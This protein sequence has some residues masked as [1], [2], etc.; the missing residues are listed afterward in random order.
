MER[1]YNNIGGSP[2]DAYNDVQLLVS[3]CRGSE[4]SQWSSNTNLIGHVSILLRI[5]PSPTYGYQNHMHDAE[6]ETI[7]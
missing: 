5:N 1:N 2:I 3:W 6:S 7:D 4:Y